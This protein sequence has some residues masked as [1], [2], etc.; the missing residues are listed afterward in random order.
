MTQKRITSIVILLCM[1][2]SMFN[3]PLVGA[4]SVDTADTG[5]QTEVAELGANVAADT[6]IE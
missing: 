4:A 2:L 6:V 1:L 3:L 5:A